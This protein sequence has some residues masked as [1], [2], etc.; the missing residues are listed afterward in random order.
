MDEYIKLKCSR[1]VKVPEIQCN[2]PFA[3][4]RGNSSVQYLKLNFSVTT[5]TVHEMSEEL[6]GF[7][8]VLV[9]NLYIDQSQ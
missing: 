2:V 9:P 5:I 6:L 8:N 1:S 4:A 3:V 7:F